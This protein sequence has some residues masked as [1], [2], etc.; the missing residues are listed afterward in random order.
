MTDWL[1]SDWLPVRRREVSEIFALLEKKVPARVLVLGSPGSGK[2]TLMYMLQDELRQRGRSSFYVPVGGMRLPGQ[3]G[4]RVLSAVGNSSPKDVLVTGRIVQSSAGVVSVSEVVEVLQRA[5]V[6]LTRPVLILDEVDAAADP[7]GT[8]SA[9]EEISKALPGWQIVVSTRKA[10]ARQGLDGFD[11]FEL[12]SLSFD[13][14]AVLMRQII[15]DATDSQIEHAVRRSD[16]LPLML[17]ILVKLDLSDLSQAPVEQLIEQYVTSVIGAMP[18]AES[19]QSLLERLALVGGRESIA[20]LVTWSGLAREEI[21]SLCNNSLVVVDSDFVAVLH[22]LVG[23][24]IVAR[25]L[26]ESPFRLADLRFGTE[27]AER[28]DLLEASFVPRQNLELILDQRR[29]VV[30]GDRGSGKSAIFRKLSVGRDDVDLFAVANPT[31]LLLK[32][33]G[34]ETQDTDTLRAA[35]LVVV[36]AVAAAAVPPSAPKALRLQAAELRAAVGLPNRP[37]GRVRRTL[38]RAARLFGGTTLSFAVGPVNL[39]TQLPDLGRRRTATVDVESFLIELDSLL[40]KTDRQA[41]VLFDRID[42]LFKYDRVRQESAVQGLL[43]VEGRITLLNSIAL[44]VL[45]RTDLFELYDIQEKNKL[46]SRRLMLEWSEEDWL[47]VLVRRVL[48]NESLAWVADRLKLPDGGFET[49]PALGVL[50]PAEV[51]G[52][53]IDRWLVDSVRN[54]NGDVSP[55]LAVLLLHLARDYSA[56][57]SANVDALP[58]FTADAIARAMTDVSELSFSEVVNDFKVGTSFVLNCRAGKRATFTL[59]DVESFFQP[60]EGAISEQVR[61]L[62]RLGFLERIVVETAEGPLSMFRIPELYTRCWEHG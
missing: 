56:R 23:L 34:T 4:G 27:E 45:L 16:G 14:A 40:G 47:Q 30:V 18:D 32:I 60:D 54:G 28:D 5:E 36:A 39:Q 42:E 20:A 24:T 2:T 35:W 1:P 52:R 26:R 19:A 46:V 7:M 50:F 41:V 62:E 38:R 43:Q 6:H 12:G 13:E 44:V 3:L 21:S 33:A 9:I 31:D 61:L 11:H 55:R 59:A 8:V 15:P 25:R 17:R 53:P 29:S 10:G 49:R 37:M 58:L 48:A 22:D 57:Q 51:E